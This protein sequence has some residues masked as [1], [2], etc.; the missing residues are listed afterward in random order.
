MLVHLVIQRLALVLQRTVS[1]VGVE[2]NEKASENH[3]H[4]LS[5]PQ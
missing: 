4:R 3:L 2:N 5:Q 1:I